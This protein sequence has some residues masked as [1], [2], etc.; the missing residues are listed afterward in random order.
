MLDLDT[1]TT[2]LRLASEGHGIKAIARWLGLSKNSVKAVVRS[3]QADV[4]KL[5]RDEQLI[6]HI[7]RVRELFASCRGNLVRVHEELASD[8]VEVAYSTLTG[9]CRRQGIGLKEARAAGRY[10]FEPGEE[11]QH[12]TS[13]HVVTVGDRSRTFHCASLVLCF[14]RRQYAQLY[15]RWTRFEA[16]VFLTEAIAWLGGAADRCMLDNS[17]VIIASGTGA[18]AIPAPAMKALADRFDF[19]FVAHVV[20]DANRSARVERPFHHIENNFYAGRTF[21]DLADLNAQLRQWC[22]TNFHRYRKRLQASPA[23][24]FVAEAPQLKPLPVYIP[25]V[26]E[27]HSRRVDIEGYV[28]LHTNRY[29][30]DARLIGRSVEIRENVDKLRIFDGHRLLEEHDKLEYGARRRRMLD[31]HQGQHRRKRKPA[32]P[33]P[34]EVLLRAQGPALGAL[35]DALR[36][37]HG[38]RATKALRR[39][40]QM[41]A[42]YPTKTV[43][44]AVSEALRHG[45]TDLGRI[46]N[47]IL[48]RIAGDFFRLP[49]D[50]DEPDD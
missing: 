7:D 25:E 9:F 37:R 22:E 1:R 20:G 5:D 24:L 4:P 32:E 16:R 21:A 38:G 19:S 33:G 44:A 15:P 36:K 3:G 49:V 14:S 48:Q 17:T 27:L 35:I 29:S 41:W 2:I 26:Y 30:V 42:D 23:E 8:K 43:V 18:D 13:P 31:K 39:L 50:K 46:D 34:H 11:M 12:D 10:H 47:M 40:H 6:E 45:L 28:N